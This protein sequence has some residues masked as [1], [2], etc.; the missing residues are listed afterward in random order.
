MLRPK[1]D[2]DRG[3]WFDFWHGS[4][5][6]WRRW[7]DRTEPTRLPGEKRRHVVYAA[8][9]IVAAA[10]FLIGWWVGLR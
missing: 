6:E 9:L 4:V 7:H 1:E 8:F 10:S 5:D 2:K 3:G